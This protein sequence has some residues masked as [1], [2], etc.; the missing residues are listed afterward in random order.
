[1]KQQFSRISILTLSAISPDEN[2]ISLYMITA[3]L[4]IQVMRI[5]EVI[6]EDKMS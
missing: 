6:T 5:K 4:N 1:M 3:C 2:E